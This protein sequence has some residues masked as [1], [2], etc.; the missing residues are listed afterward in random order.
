MTADTFVG[1][2]KEP[3]GLEAFLIEQGYVVVEKRKGVAVLFERKDT[4]WPQIFYSPQVIPAE[5]KDEC[6]NWKK[7]R[8]KIVSEVDINYHLDFEFIEEAE[9]LSKELTKR[10][11]GVLCQTTPDEA[12]FKAED[13]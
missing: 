7:S 1:F 9:R 11:N 12:Y 2:R 3:I 8:V 6:P 5:D 10:Y 13:L 4:I